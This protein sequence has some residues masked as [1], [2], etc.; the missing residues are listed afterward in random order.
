[1]KCEILKTRRE[2]REEGKPRIQH[3]IK[4]KTISKS[5]SAIYLHIMLLFG[6]MDMRKWKIEIIN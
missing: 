4:T 1:M 6:Q 5:K 2:K 3:K